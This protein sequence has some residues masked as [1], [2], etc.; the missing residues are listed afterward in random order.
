MKD[1]II[2]NKITSYNIVM[3]IVIES[4]KENDNFSS[5]II[6]SWQYL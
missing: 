4:K 6:F 3:N 5:I 1:N 2:E